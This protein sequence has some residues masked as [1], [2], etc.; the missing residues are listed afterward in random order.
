MI[1]A[2]FLKDHPG[3]QEVER[4]SYKRQDRKDRGQTSP[5]AIAIAQASDDDEAWATVE[6]RDVVGRGSIQNII[7]R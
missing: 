2:T 7:G 1:Q 6:V 5:E 4:R 3:I